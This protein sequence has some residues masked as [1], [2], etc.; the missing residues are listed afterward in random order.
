[1]AYEY[2]TVIQGAT[3]DADA[4]SQMSQSDFIN[5]L[6]SIHAQILSKVTS[7]LVSLRGGGWEI[8]SHNQSL[9]GGRIVVSFL[10]RRPER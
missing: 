6:S 2:S 5:K 4:L 1:M 3:V 7:A 9:I 10:L 8:V